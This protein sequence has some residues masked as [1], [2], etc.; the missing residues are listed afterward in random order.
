MKKILLAGDTHGNTQHMKNI[1][2][3]ATIHRVDKIIQLGDFGYKWPY[4]DSVETTCQGI[5]DWSAQEFGIEWWF[6]PGNHDNYNEMPIYADKPVRI[7]EGFVF[8]PRGV[9]WEENGVTFLGMGG[10]YSIDKGYR[11][12][13][14]SWWEREIPADWEWERA[15]DA[16]R[17]KVI[18]SH[19]VMLGVDT[20]SHHDDDWHRF[21]ESRYVREN[22]RSLTEKHRPE[23]IF[24]GH[25]HVR[26]TESVPIEN[27]PS[28]IVHGIGADIN[29]F[30]DS[31]IVIEIDYNG[32]I[33]LKN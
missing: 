24:H 16:P 2:N 22:L 10:A 33:S 26:Y 31:Y 15:M 17:A 11:T 13:N 5:C 14:I 30:G 8:V 1:V 19:D 21:P 28:V 6:I 23:L 18:L 9:T 4:R 27:G 7:S 25:H 12:P 32:E 29:S 3:T 20:F